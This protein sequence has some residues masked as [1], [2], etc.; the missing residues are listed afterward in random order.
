MKFFKYILVTQFLI[1][2]N[3]VSFSQSSI[4]AIAT[5]EI[6]EVLKASE[7]NSLNFGRF[8]PELVGGEIRLT[9]DGVRTSVGD[10]ALTGGSYN[11]AAFQVAG[12]SDAT[13][14]IILPVGSVVLV[15]PNTGKT[16]EVYKWEANP[17]Q[18]GGTAVLTKGSLLLKVGATLKVGT[19][20][21][22]PVGKY[23]G[24]YTITFSYD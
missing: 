16:L 13:L 15:N 3:L 23:S 10:V 4:R 9:P 17:I 19:F 14:N 2:F 20:S 22:N 24:T 5:A 1:G 8:S 12:Q 18:N 11:P 7:I 21:E 6:I